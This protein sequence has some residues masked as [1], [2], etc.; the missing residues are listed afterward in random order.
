MGRVRRVRV[1]LWTSEKV[2]RSIQIEFSED[3]K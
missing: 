1:I 2:K 3:F